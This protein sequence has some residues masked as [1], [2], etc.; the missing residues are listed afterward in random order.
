[1]KSDVMKSGPARAPARAMLRSLLDHAPRQLVSGEADGTWQG[2]IDHVDSF[3][4]TLVLRATVAARRDH[5][6][7]ARR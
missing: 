6:A 7:G 2:D 3:G 4:E 1:M 5:D